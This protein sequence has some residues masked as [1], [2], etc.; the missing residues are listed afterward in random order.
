MSFIGW[1]GKRLWCSVAGHRME[2]SRIYY[3]TAKSVQSGYRC[4]RCRKSQLFLRR[5]QEVH[6]A[7]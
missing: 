3:A 7:E 1:L 6:D 4:A 2:S 5:W